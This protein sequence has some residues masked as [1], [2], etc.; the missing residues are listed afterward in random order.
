MRAA[1]ETER[2]KQAQ[3]ADQLS[4]ARNAAAHTLDDFHS[5]THVGKEQGDEALPHV[6]KGEG[7]A[8]R[9]V[10]TDGALLVSTE[11]IT[12]LSAWWSVG[13]SAGEEVTSCLSVSNASCL[14][15]SH[16]NSTSFFK[17]SVRGL[18]IDE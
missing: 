2:D 18:A 4:A 12:G 16:I 15:S 9:V 13:L 3:L 14:L 10:F 5:V 7:E 1:A 17:S 8:P 6:R 11:S